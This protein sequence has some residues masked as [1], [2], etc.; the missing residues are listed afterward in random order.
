LLFQNLKDDGGGKI[1]TSGS[2]VSFGA[3]SDSVYEYM[4][5]VWVQGG[6]KESM[7][8]EMWDKSMQGMHDQLLQKSTPNGLSYIAD[9]QNDR[10]D[11]KMDHLVCFMGGALALGAYTD[12][13]GL[14]SE[15]AQRDLRSAKALTYTCYQ[16][17]ARTKT[18]IAP[19]FVQFSGGDDMVV[20]RS[21]PFYI[22]RPETVEAFYY[23]SKL[24]GDPIYRVS[25]SDAGW[26]T[27][28]FFVNYT[29]LNQTHSTFIQCVD[30]RSGDGRCF[31]ASK[32]TAKQNMA[33][34]H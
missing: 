9:R 26:F 29:Y 17:Y 28:S 25:Y 11:R 2:K 12:P 32:S 18:G 30:K 13:R 6:R 20:P 14:E 5:K 24:T 19:E 15:R 27:A 8:R 4:L 31:R 23:L 10:L 34:A 21:A 22:L 16:M 33:M 1:K 3:M 7:Y